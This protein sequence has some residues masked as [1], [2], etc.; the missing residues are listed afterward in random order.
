M[1][2]GL[3][4]PTINAFDLNFILKG[5]GGLLLLGVGVAAYRSLF[6]E[7]PLYELSAAELA[8]SSPDQGNTD[9]SAPTNT[10]DR[11]QPL[12]LIEEAGARRADRSAL[13]AQ[14]EATT[15]R[16]RPQ[17]LPR[18]NFGFPSAVAIA[19][20]TASP[21]ESSD[22]TI[23]LT[24]RDLNPAR[25]TTTDLN[26][27][28]HLQ[29][30]RR[31]EAA[32][33]T[34]IAVAPAPPRVRPQLP[35]L[36]AG[37]ASA[38]AG[39]EPIEPL[40]VS[41]LLSPPPLAEVGAEAGAEAGTGPVA[42]VSNAAAPNPAD[43]TAPQ[44]FTLPGIQSTAGQPV[45]INPKDGIFVDQFKI[46]GNTVFSAEELARV[47][48]AALTPD[49]AIDYT[50]RLQT[51]ETKLARVLTP[52]ELI[53]ASDAITRYYTD[54]GFVNSGAYVP[55]DVLKGGTPEIRVV[56]GG[57][58]SIQVSIDPPKSF[59]LAMP[60]NR[61]YVEQRIAQ[62]MG[63]PL[64]LNRLLEGV[65]QLELD[66][67]I[68]SIDT[69][70]SPG[71]RTGQSILKVRVRQAK[72]FGASFQID[73]SRSSSVGS[74][75]QLLTLQQANIL[76]LGDRLTASYGRTKGSNSWDLG[77]TIPINPKDGTLSLRYNSSFG[78][79]IE[80]PFAD[81]NIAST[82]RTYEVK[83][84]QPIV[85]KPEEEIAVSLT[86][87]RYNSKGTIVGDQPLP[88]RGADDSGRTVV[89]AIRLGQEWTKKKPKQLLSFQSELSLGVNALGATIKDEAPDGQFM[90][91]R[92]R[93]QLV[94]LVAPDTIWTVR[95][96]LQLADRPLVPSE[97]FSLGGVDTVRG[98]RP[99][100]LLSDG[101]WLA[102][103]ELQI[104][105]MRFPKSKGLVQIAPFL[106]MG[107]GWNQGGDAPKT[108]QLMSTGLGI[109]WKQG[110]R[111]T[112]RL[113]WGFPLRA[114]DKD[115]RQDGPHFS[116]LL[117]P[118]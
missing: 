62:A 71:V 94:R 92:G 104:P 19:P 3:P 82:S 31:P 52:A 7:R 84:R 69:E 50:K 60:L 77:Y 30:Q 22:R 28:R 53:T 79:I 76:G 37:T 38:Q 86:A 14:P 101:G 39:S 9:R 115:I 55:E 56:E 47:T 12:A 65:K 34:T 67:L 95:G 91:W 26:I 49:R 108:S 36:V 5:L 100:T 15:I 10:T 90:S 98:Y 106:D 57:I 75:R 103:T 72:T 20:P 18:Q 80:E 24:P 99:N 21:I 23:Q 64:N 13:A 33:A 83:L 105:V 42:A 112:A 63:S 25:S 116:I 61:G 4:Q 117:R 78:R 66:P 81:L 73:N 59:G 44:P 2:T 97:Q 70:L 109:I 43:T 35:Q 32:A 29:Q 74:L 1:T 118:F 11:P 88:T 111:F 113:D 46:A 89:T 17:H 87:S 85:K 27:A 93:G 114:V 16:L 48:H 107:G 110:N 40:D 8:S 6:Q 68:E 54:K 58:E 96:E 51:G 102:S 41:M 45:A